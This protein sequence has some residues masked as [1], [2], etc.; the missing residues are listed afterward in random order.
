MSRGT[1]L[2]LYK[3][4]KLKMDDDVFKNVVDKYAERN[5]ELDYSDKKKPMSEYRKDIPIV[6]KIDPFRKESEYDEK[7]GKWKEI[8]V[9]KSIDNLM[10]SVVGFVDS[11]DRMYCTKMMDWTFGSSFDCLIDHFGIGS[12]SYSK[13]VVEITVDVANHMLS[14][15]D[16]LLGGAWNDKGICATNP[17]VRLFSEGYGGDSYWKYVYRDRHIGGKTFNIKQ[18]GFD[19]TIK[20][21]KVKMTE[22]DLYGERERDESNEWIEYSLEKFRNGLTAFLKSD[23]SEMYGDSDG[24]LGYRYDYKFLLTYEF[25]G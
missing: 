7:T 6:M 24:W 21:P 22:D 10:R 19:I 1:T 11:R 15:I 23:Y 2:T 16:Y 18:D 9:E 5:R 12:Y 25:W 3:K 17:Y 14:A 20:C 13:S 4:F 8:A